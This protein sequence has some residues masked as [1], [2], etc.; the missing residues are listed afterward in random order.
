M[1]KD[2]NTMIGRR[3]KVMSLLIKANAIK[4]SISSKQELMKNLD[5]AIKKLEEQKKTLK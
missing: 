2:G 3:M 1:T 5:L 4:K